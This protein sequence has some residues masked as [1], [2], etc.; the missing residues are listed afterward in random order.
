MRFSFIAAE[1]AHYP[2]EVLCRVLGVSRS[3][4]YAWRKRRPSP[5]I[6]ADEQ[7]V[8]RIAHVHQGSR[9]TYGSP[10]VHAALAGDGVRVSRKRVIR[11]MR[12]QGLAGRR[13]R[14]F[15]TTT[16]STHGR[17]IA[18]NVLQRRF[19]VDRPDLA[20]A[21]DVT[22][23]WTDEGWLYL[24]VLLDLYSRKIVGWAMSDRLDTAL[25][26][27]ALDMALK[28]RKPA[29]GLIH[30]S[31][32]GSTYAA[33]EYRD[34]LAR[35][36]FV[37]S[38]SRRRDCWDNAVAESFFSTLKNELIERRPITGRAQTKSAVFDY[39]EVFYNRQRIH[40]H[41][42]FKSPAQREQDFNA[43]ALTQ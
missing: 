34:M 24:A 25:C 10:R 13:R 9:A 32:R 42:G 27:S 41:C 23:L 4:Y 30:H 18:P 8:E 17:P 37:A 6:Q 28:A 15:R 35:G 14:R 2:V 26:A 29:R 7:L 40:S 3:G 11:L 43:V 20:W 12:E 38:M 33:H 19:D 31:D 5:R 1:K 22:Y 36:G 39:I 21:G 16:D